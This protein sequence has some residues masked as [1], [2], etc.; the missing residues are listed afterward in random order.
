[1]EHSLLHLQI[2]FFR[3]HEVQIQIYMLYFF[4]LHLLSL[5]SILSKILKNIYF[6][7]QIISLSI[8]ELFLLR[9][10]VILHKVLHYI[11]LKIFLLVLRNNILLNCFKNINSMD[12]HIRIKLICNLHIHNFKCIMNSLLLLL[13]LLSIVS[14]LFF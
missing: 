8:H 4:N 10:L 11:L 5:F 7:S 6:I 13:M 1:M 12:F 9:I 3:Q 14:L 2:Y